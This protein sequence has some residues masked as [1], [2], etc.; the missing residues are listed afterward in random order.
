MYE[1]HFGLSSNPFSSS[2]SPEFIYESREHREALAHFQFA[3]SN[4]EAFV[5]LTGEVGTGKTTAVQSL[6]RHLPAGAPV[7]VVTHTTL[8]P[9]ELLE[10]IALRFGLEPVPGES[11]PALMRR[12]ENYLEDHRRG[13]GQALLVLDEAHLMSPALLEEVRLLSNLESPEGGK[14]LQIC[15]VGQPELESHLQQPQLRQLRQRISVRYAL[16]PL[17]RDETRGYI[18]HRLAAAGCADPVAVFPPEACDAVHTLSQGIPREINVLASQ[19]L[20]NA[21]LDEKPA[22]VRNHVFSAK[23]DYGFQ[24]IVTGAAALS[25]EAPA[26]PPVPRRV[27]TDPVG[28]P[29]RRVPPPPRVPKSPPAEPTGPPPASAGAPPRPVRRPIPLPPSSLRPPPRPQPARAAPPAAPIAGGEPER[30]GAG[31]R[32]RVTV[33]PGRRRGDRPGPRK[34]G[35]WILVGLALAVAVVAVFIRSQIAPRSAVTLDPAVVDS[36]AANLAR[37]V[38]PGT[39]PPGTAL[40]GNPAS[41]AAAS[42]PAAGSPEPA[43]TSADTGASAAPAPPPLPAEGGERGTAPGIRAGGEAGVPAASTA[44]PEDSAGGPFTIQVASFHTRAR[45]EQ[46][47]AEVTRLTGFPAAILP[48]RVGGSDW[49]RL[50]LGSFPSPEAAREAAEPLVRNRTIHEVM[51]I[52]VPEGAG[53]ALSGDHTP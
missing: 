47:L 34:R 12:M 16:K 3:L 18:H 30:G 8:E 41:G 52:P 14:L 32:V 2:P 11:K 45:A 33:E 1:A 43:A 46:V 50:F 19:A 25:P 9:R 27:P 38:P 35:V 40:P 51:V 31:G 29:P 42:G 24:G 39:A 7:A 26:P 6:R 20:L 4:R 48:A 49:L 53:P 23:S 37:T 21:F 15:L 5:L 28:P 10:E 36:M 13:G 44:A 17:G 22:V